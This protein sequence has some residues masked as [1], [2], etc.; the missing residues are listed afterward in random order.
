ER[1]SNTGEGGNSGSGQR[2]CGRGELAK[3]LGLGQDVPD[4]RRQGAAHQRQPPRRRAKA[5][6]A[7]GRST[8]PTAIARKITAG[9]KPGSPGPPKS[10]TFQRA[11]TA[12]VAKAAMVNLASPDSGARVGSITR[13]PKRL[14]PCQELSRVRARFQRW[15]GNGLRLKTRLIPFRHIW[16]NSIF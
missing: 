7:C 5:S 9:A 2:H 1:S 14:V 15:I 16:C 4:R 13:P 10:N 11:A 3:S 8:T 12:I 6:S